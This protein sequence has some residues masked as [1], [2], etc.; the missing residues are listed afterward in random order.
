[1]LIQREFYIE[2]RTCNGGRGSPFHHRRIDL[3][4]DEANSA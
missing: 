4:F 2:G 1:L 3:F